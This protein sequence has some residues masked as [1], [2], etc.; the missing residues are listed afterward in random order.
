MR[1]YFYVS[2]AEIS[3]GMTLIHRVE[4]KQ[5]IQLQEKFI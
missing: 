2:N 1:Y 4:I 3:N 5:V